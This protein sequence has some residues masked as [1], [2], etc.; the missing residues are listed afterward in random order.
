[1]GKFGQ[2]AVI[3]SGLA[4]LTAAAR[5]R[6]AGIAATVFDKGRQPGGRLATRRVAPGY[7][8]NHGCQFATARD[9]GFESLLRAHGAL[10]PAAGQG[11]YAGVPDMAALAA[12]A[13]RGLGE[14]PRQSAEIASLARTAAGWHLTMRDGGAAGPFEALVLA[15]PAPQAERLLRTAGHHFAQALSGVR[16]APCWAL[17]LGFAEP[18]A[19]PAVLAPRAG[20][21][22]WVARENARPAAAAAPLAYTLHA[23]PAWS[24]AQLE[25]SAESVAPPLLAAFAAATGIAAPPAYVK[26]HRW[27]YARTQAP[28]GEAFLWDSA[29]QIGLCG[30]WCLGGRLEAAYLSG[31]DLGIRMAHD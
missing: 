3:G 19:G 22:A 7:I 30:D 25:N 4:G 2:V 28:L 6:A 17:L 29:T 1:M 18:L 13:A 26:A 31:R 8:F 16:M 12:A 27:R 9:A 5:L 20:P 23:T 21:L 15:V 11:R 24:A 14:A 10:W